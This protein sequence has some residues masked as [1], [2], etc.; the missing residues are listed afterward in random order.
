[1]E[2][3]AKKTIEL[4]N[5]VS[6]QVA[7]KQEPVP[8]TPR[9][10]LRIPTGARVGATATI[11]DGIALGERFEKYGSEIAELRRIVSFLDRVFESVRQLMMCCID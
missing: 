2:A 9:E 11:K 4:R 8:T 1:L 3:Q 5:S 6:H 7:I 10:R